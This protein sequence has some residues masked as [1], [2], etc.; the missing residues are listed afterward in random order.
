MEREKSAIAGL[1][2]RRVI[3]PLLRAVYRVEAKKFIQLFACV[4]TLHHKRQAMPSNI[5]LEHLQVV[6]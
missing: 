6:A 3:L 2:L 1:N 4:N 5:P